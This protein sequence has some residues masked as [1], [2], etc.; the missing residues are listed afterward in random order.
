MVGF[1]WAGILLG[2]LSLALLALANVLVASLT[3]YDVPN[4]V[5]DLGIGITA[6]SVAVAFS[7]HLYMQ[8]NRK[9]DL[10]LDLVVTRLEDL[11]SRVG[12]HNTGF[13]E[14]Y[15]LNQSREASVVPFAP[16]LSRR[17]TADG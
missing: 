8:V 17:G 12:D 11:E 2:T 5:N 7:A 9:L 4:V 16:H 3:T 15:L 1:K 6:A 14:G 13:V 10:M